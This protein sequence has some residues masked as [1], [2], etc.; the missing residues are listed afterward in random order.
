[1]IGIKKDCGSI[2]CWLPDI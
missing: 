2:L 1:M